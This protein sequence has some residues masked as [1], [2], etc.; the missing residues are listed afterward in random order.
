M[1]MFEIQGIQ[2]IELR[3]IQRHVRAEVLRQQA[4]TD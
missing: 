4:L 1:D 2:G 3:E